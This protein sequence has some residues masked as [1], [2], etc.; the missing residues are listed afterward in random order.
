MTAARNDTEG[1]LSAGRTP[2][3]ATVAAVLP[4][5]LFRLRLDDGSVRTGHVT[6][7]LRMAS[8]RLLPGDVVQIEV[9][10]FDPTKA[11]ISARFAPGDR[12]PRTRTNPNT[13]QSE[14][15]P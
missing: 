15:Q 5:E 8:T 7:D 10:P 3:R 4:N 9:S 1:T 14:I 6:G 11:R 12:G 2:V 13:N